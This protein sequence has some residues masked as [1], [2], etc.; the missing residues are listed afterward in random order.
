MDSRTARTVRER[1]NVVRRDG[2]RKRRKIITR[3]GQALLPT[4]PTVPIVPLP[5]SGLGSVSIENEIGAQMIIPTPSSDS[6]TRTYQ[7]EGFISH[8][9]VLSYDSITQ[10]MAMHDGLQPR[11]LQARDIILGAT[12][13]N[14]LPAPSLRKAL[15]DSFIENVLPYCPVVDCKDLADENSS[16]LLQLAVCLVGSLMRHDSSSLQLSYSLYEKIQALLYIDFENDN[17]TL[18][19]TF[20][21]L[22]CWA[23]AS[24]Y[25]VTL[26]GPW[27]WTGMAN[28]ETLMVACWGRPRSLKLEDCDVQPLAASD[29]AAEGVSAMVSLHFTRLMNVV[30]IVAELNTK[31]GVPSE[32]EVEGIIASLCN[33]YRGLPEEL[34]LHNQNGTRRPF[35]R[36]TSELH[37]HYLTTIILIQM[38]SKDRHSPWRTSPASIVAASCVAHLYEEIHCREQAVHLLSINGFL[39]LVAAIVLVFQRPQS[40]EKE[41]IRNNGVDSI[42]S[43][44]RTMCTK[45]G[46]PR[47]VLKRVQGLQLNAEGREPPANYHQNDGPASCAPWVARAVSKHVDDL[48]P[49]PRSL[50]ENMVILGLAEIQSDDLSVHA[51]GAADSMPF[52]QMSDS[53]FSLMD[54]LEMDFDV[55]ETM[56]GCI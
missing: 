43:V 25:R 10:P 36:L 37:I 26:H 30:R 31:K 53:G 15:T 12:Q 8:S 35:H 42:C 41:V 11:I 22:S 33:W 49:F 20:C 54:I 24:P 44:L 32:H 2:V 13:A 40:P 48:F 51:A 55:F 28:T 19:K 7:S 4:S 16:I 3:H 56:N 50:C 21:L 6:S 14:I 38:L 5:P 27:H 18:L 9:S 46:G 17:M 39:A 23:P 47:S 45:Y 34:R 52:E 1:A 29:F